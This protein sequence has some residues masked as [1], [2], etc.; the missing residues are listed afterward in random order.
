[1]QELEAGLDAV[2]AA[3][4]DEGSLDLIVRRPQ[5]DAREILRE[6]ELDPSVGLV[7]DSWQ[8]R[9][10]SRSA[11]HGPHP[12]MQLNIMNSRAISLVAGSDD[13]WALAGDQLFVDLDLGRDNLP[14]GTRLGIGEAVIEITDQPHT[15]CAKFRDRFG[16][17]A[18]RL[19]NSPPG[20]ELN[21][22][23]VCAKVVQGGTIRVGDTVRKTAPVYG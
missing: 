2:R 5:V 10:S 18:L 7:G 4:K 13:R 15:G 23:G 19:V 1:M 12:D 22:R 11:D 6:G 8:L 16:R 3:P 17:D 9:E 21:L 20:R 14:T